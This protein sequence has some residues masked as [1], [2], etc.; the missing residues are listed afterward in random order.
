M[1]GSYVGTLDAKPD[2]Q[3]AQRLMPYAVGLTYVPAGDS[4]PG[5]LLFLREGTLMA[6]PFDAKR[7]ALAGNPVP[8]AER[9]GSFRDGGFFLRLRPTTSWCIASTTPISSSPGSIGRA[10]EPGLGTGRVSQR[11]SFPDGARAVASRTEP[12]GQDKGR[13]LAVRSVAAA[14]GPHD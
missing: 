11:G 4:D 10:R 9:V 7:L 12:A 13:P 1:S 14:V 6:Q 8:I 5:R 2:E 3:S